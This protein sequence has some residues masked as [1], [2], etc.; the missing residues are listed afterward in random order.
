MVQGAVPA[1]DHVDPATHAAAAP[2]HTVFAVAV[3]AVFTPAAPHV[4]AAAHVVQGAL[5]ESENDVPT[6]HGVTSPG[7]GTGPGLDAGIVNPSGTTHCPGFPP[8]SG[9]V[10]PDP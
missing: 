2:S 1:A 6:S 4:E 9:P 5:P 7:F 8:A 3:Q 10:C